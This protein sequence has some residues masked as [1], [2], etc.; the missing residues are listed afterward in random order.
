MNPASLPRAQTRVGGGYGDAVTPTPR[1]LSRIL[2]T[3]AACAAG[4]LTAPPASAD[5]LDHPGPV[6]YVAEPHDLWPGGDLHAAAELPVGTEPVYPYPQPA[7]PPAAGCATVA[8]PAAPPASSPPALQIIYAYHADNPNRYEQAAETIA[9]VI[10]RV[11]WSLDNSSDYDQHLELNCSRAPDGSYADYARALVQPLRVTTADPTFVSSG[12]VRADLHAAGYTDPNRWYVVFTDFDSESDAYLCPQTGGQWCSAVGELW[13]SG[14]FGHEMGHLLGAGHAWMTQKAE[15]YIP[16]VMYGWWDYWLFDTGYNTYYDPSERTASFHIDPSPST[17]RANIA[18]HPALTT[19]VPGD[20]G[21][22]NDLLTAQERTV[23][24]TAPSTAAP[25]FSRIGTT[26]LQVAS[27]CGTTGQS[28]TFFDGR[29]SLAVV[30]NQSE[31][32]FTVTRRPAVTPGDTYK[33]FVRM[34]GDQPGDTV[35]RM[36]W[37][38]AAGNVIST[39]QS[40]RIPTDTNWYEY[41]LTATAP[42]TAA[43]VSVGVAVPAGQAAFTFLADTLQLNHCPAGQCR[44]DT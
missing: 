41:R 2:I 9:E 7:D 3:A 10:D 33:L 42:A 13:D 44:F 16:D 8:D 24:A 12:D 20:G 30:A 27:A 5:P 39:S 35:L 26:Y 29:R 18:N 6:G 43:T 14:L 37:Y 19:P 21:P 25:G 1:H 4:I 34:R 15:N 40:A 31:S 32:G 11:D 36:R 38:D 23:E 22:H 28:C 17:T